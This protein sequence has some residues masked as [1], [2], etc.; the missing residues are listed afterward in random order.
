M[1]EYV[2]EAKP[3]IIEQDVRTSIKIAVI[4]LVIGAV[5]WGLGWVL[6]RFVLQGM[7]CDG[8][9][10]CGA[11]TTYAGNIA[12]VVAAIVAVVV[13]VRV[14]VFRPL[15]IVLGAVLSL[16]G[17]L[18]WTSDMELWMQALVS[19]GLYALLYSVYAWIARIR[20]PAIMLVVFVIIVACSRVV[21]L[22]V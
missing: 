13:L 14:N 8:S 17:L 4:G 7:L 9:A 15:L 21:P 2:H 20:Q 18:H 11:A 10:M 3:A 12:G 5:A 22:I 19:A 1:V 6:E 16:W